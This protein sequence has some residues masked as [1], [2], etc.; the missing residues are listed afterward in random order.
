M[1]MITISKS[2]DEV[3]KYVIDAQYWTLWGIQLDKAENVGTNIIKATYLDSKDVIHW[4]VSH[5]TSGAV[6]IVIFTNIA[7]S[8]T[9]EYIFTEQGATTTVGRNA[10]TL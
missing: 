8:Q 7:T 9:V 4:Q 1:A 2:I 10:D 5:K 3:V 6:Q